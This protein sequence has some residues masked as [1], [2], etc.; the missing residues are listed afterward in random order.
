MSQ[1]LSLIIACGALLLLL[2][3]S[4]VGGMITTAAVFALTTGLILYKKA[5]ALTFEK[6]EHHF[7]F[8]ISILICACL[9][10]N[11]Y[12][13]WSTAA[14]G[15]KQGA[16]LYITIRVLLFVAALALMTLSLNLIHAAI[17]WLCKKLSD[18]TGKNAFTRELASC[19]LAAVVTVV[20][21]QTMI[22]TAAFSMG[23]FKFLV[24]VLIVAA[25]ILLLYCLL[26]RCIPA[27]AVGAGLFMVI[28]T[29]NVY[30][31]KFRGRLFEPVDIFS[32][33]TAMNVMGNYNL[34][35][36]PFTI[37]SGW[38]LFAAMLMLL[39]HLQHK[40]RPSIPLKKRLALLAVCATCSV[41]IFFYASGL[42]T[43]HWHKQ[44]AEYNG[45]V[46]DFVSKFKEVTVPEPESYSMELIDQLADQYRIPQ[47]EAQVQRSQL[48]H[49]IV[50]MDESFSDLKV[51]G[52]LATNTEIMP[53]ISSLKE[54]TISGYALSSVYGGNTANSEY[55]FLTGNS[56]V[57]LS[58]N[59]VP[60]QQY[61]RSSTYSMVS[62]L[63]SYYDYKAIAMHPYGSSGWNR[64]VAYQHLGFEEMYFVEAFP[65]ENIIRDYVSDQE[66]FDFLIET[67]EANKDEPLLI[68]SVTMQNHGGYTYEGDN[69]TK[70]VSLTD[71]ADEF[72]E[73]EQYLSLVHETDKAVENLISYFQEVEEDVV[74]VFFGDH[75]PRIDEAFYEAVSDVPADTLD[76]QQKRYMVPFFIWTNYDIEEKTIDC[77]SLNYLA[78][79]VYD[80]A[81]IP[82]PPYN[83]FLREM[84]AQVP[85]INA[86]GF[87]SLDAGRY[88]P[89]EEA[90]EAEL[91]WLDLYEALQYNN[92]FDKENL[93]QDL[94]P[95]LAE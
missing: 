14:A 4:S 3:S 66:M 26:T 53:F 54:N 87:Y 91:A 47:E 18:I 79:Y 55:E 74:I 50:I 15:L 23:F 48:P 24:C 67:F 7:F 31:Y 40:T 22:D 35:P 10:L 27:I 38:C 13:R 86:N 19:L 95:L 81:G 89:L 25:A 43:Y 56:L 80:A 52:D 77:T 2:M 58:P 8:P 12:D 33:G 49:I 39:G 46:L 62:Y 6:S 21:S 93:N 73:V 92:L 30:V 69:F 65:Q 61:I 68:H 51:V 63:R 9:G 84:E 83:R 41:A 75:Q 1:P 85:C 71:H 28:S 88:L 70:H 42:K 72:P 82:L 76:E 59:V 60:Y 78:S 29:I 37:L 36:I 5:A 90:N 94:F 17:H 57:W 32:A 45:S 64:P 20:L 16:A 34:F 44:G 11:F